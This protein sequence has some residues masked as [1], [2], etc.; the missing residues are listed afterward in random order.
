MNG[1]KV[2]RGNEE[3]KSRLQVHHLARILKG[4]YT[5]DKASTRKVVTGLSLQ[6]ILKLTYSKG[7]KHYFVVSIDA[8]FRTIPCGVREGKNGHGTAQQIIHYTGLSTTTLDGQLCPIRHQ[9]P[10]NLSIEVQ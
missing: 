2:A 3:R 7:R 6:L 1:P 10:V 9:T 4:P 8:A 5:G